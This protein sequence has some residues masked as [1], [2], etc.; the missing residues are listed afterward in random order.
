METP[1]ISI[2]TLEFAEGT[3]F[4]QVNCVSV[5]GRAPKELG[6]LSWWAM[7]SA[8]RYLK[9]V[10]R[11][12]LEFVERNFHILTQSMPTLPTCSTLYAHREQAQL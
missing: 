8:P 12:G 7:D 4:G 1:E 10:G 5:G 3:C 9:D 6:E 11:A 2:R